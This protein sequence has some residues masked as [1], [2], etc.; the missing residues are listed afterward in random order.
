[1]IILLEFRK[2]RSI[3]FLP[4]YIF[5]ISNDQQWHFIK[6]PHTFIKYTFAMFDLREKKTQPKV[7][8]PLKTRHHRCNNGIRNLFG[9]FTYLIHFNF[10][11]K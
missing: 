7:N 4:I 5:L 11:R 3:I 10:I 1:M 8:V 2:D 9:M 6:K